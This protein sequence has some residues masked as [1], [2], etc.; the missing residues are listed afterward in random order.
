M[1][2]IRDDQP[3]F[4]TPYVTYF[5]I[6]LNLVIFLF[7]A[8]L[9]PQ[10]FKILLFQLGMVPAN[11]TAFLGGTGRPGVVA[12][13]LPTLTS[14]FLHGGWLHLLGNMLF[15]WVFGRNIE[16][17][18]G[19]GRFRGDLRRSLSARNSRSIYSRR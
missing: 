6:G 19:G 5:L 18:I 12:A 9:T 13:F 14:M 10:S 17:L 2:P 7:E 11:I 8:S 1:I 16:D 3:R 4:S 15:L